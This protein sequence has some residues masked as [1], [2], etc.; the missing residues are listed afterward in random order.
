MI[1]IMN[2]FRSLRRA[3]HPLLRG[4]RPGV[5]LYPG[6]A[7][8]ALAVTFMAVT[9]LVPRKIAV[10]GEIF[11]QAE[12]CPPPRGYRLVRVTL[13][14]DAPIEGT[15]GRK[16][17]KNASAAF[18]IE[19]ETVLDRAKLP[20]DDRA[21]IVSRDYL[22]PTDSGGRKLLSGLGEDETAIPLEGRYLDD[23]DYPAIFFRCARLVARSG[24]A[25][26]A[27]LEA[28]FTQAFPVPPEEEI[29]F[30][31]AVGDLM[32]GRG[33]ERLLAREG[34]L[35]LVFGDALPLLR[36]SD[37]LIGNLEG[38]V[39]GGTAKATKTYTF[40]YAPRIL[41]YLRDA[42]FDYLMTTNN[43]SFDYGIEG[44]TDT[45]A[46]LRDAGIATSGAGENLAEARRFWRTTIKGQALSVLSLGAYPV[47]RTGFDGSRTAAAGETKAGILWESPGIPE[48][49]RAEKE[50]GAFV[51][52]CVHGG[53]EYRTAPSER[54]KAFYRKLADSGCDVVFGS[55]PHVLQP[56]EKRG[57][58]LIVYSLG[59]F[60]FPGMEGMP[61]AEESEIVRLGV[62][63]GRIVYREVYP[64]R[65][66][67]TRV[68]LGDSVIY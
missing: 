24:K 56:L 14:P 32:P 23:P 67:G 41:G 44:F 29:V 45:L 38:A 52:V 6:L 22:V 8:L 62:L 7:V 57:G 43:H 39:T 55:H 37:L 12:A 49:V 26:P 36:S 15:E 27:K 1:P 42:G 48:L 66:S 58:K 68:A 16:A 59:N 9:L 5:A 18:A 63:K 50:T 33:V 34:G 2:P 17:G 3:I 4:N 47:E 10:P 25:V 53:E 51:I 54:Q 31:S 20:A 61:G 65:L 60:L 30:V 40:K 46:A 11:A 19:L 64:A 28:W 21:R 35:E 13:P